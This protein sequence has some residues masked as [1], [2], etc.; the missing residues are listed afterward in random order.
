MSGYAQ[1]TQPDEAFVHRLIERIGQRLPRPFVVPV[2]SA[3]PPLTDPTNLWL[4]RDGRLRSRYQ[5]TDGT[6][7][8]REYAPIT[9]TGTAPPAAPTAGTAPKTKVGTWNAD[10]SASYVSSGTKRVDA[11]RLYYGSNGDSNGMQRSL[12]GFD[13]V[14]IATALAGSTV[15]SVRLFLTNLN[16]WYGDGSR[17]HFGVHDYA[18]EPATWAGSGIPQSMVT[19]HH[20]GNPEGK[21]V[22]LPLSFATSI[23]DGTG[24]GV[25]LES[26]NS[27]LEF[28]GYAAG[29]GS[30]FSVPI[31][32]VT[33]VK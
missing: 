26:P 8:T 32:E 24:A 31:L 20:F 2:L 10:W 4:L 3:D 29:L 25:A 28:Y 15:K 33:Y 11:G 7:V 5:Q 17:I 14:A 18:T 9:P 13:E 21:W 22:T 6:W 12:I 23:R 30:G 19:S 16:S 1:P 27:S